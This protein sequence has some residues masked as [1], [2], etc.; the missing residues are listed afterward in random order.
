MPYPQTYS[1]FGAQLGLGT[2][3]RVSRR[4]AIG[5]DVVGFIRGRTDDK[6]SYA[7]EFVD[8]NTGR[9]TNT[10]GGGLVRVGATFYW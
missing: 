8:P 9:A 3:V 5:G 1:Y 4:I 6:A 7:P 10:S 2:E